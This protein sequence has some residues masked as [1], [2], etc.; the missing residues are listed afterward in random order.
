MVTTHSV[1]SDKDNRGGSAP[2]IVWLRQDLRL[3]DNPALQAACRRGGPVVPVFIWA[4]EEEGAWPPGSAS[5]W[6]LHQSL[7]RLAGEFRAAGR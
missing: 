1:R 7:A 2:A 4:P 5:R 6:W 3:A